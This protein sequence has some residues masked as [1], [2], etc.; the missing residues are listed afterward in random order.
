MLGANM[1]SS[2]ISPRRYAEG[3]D[4]DDLGSD[5]DSADFVPLSFSLLFGSPVQ[6]SPE[7]DNAPPFMSDT[8]G[9]TVTRCP[10]LCSILS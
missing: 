5:S 3:P 2:I 7:F 10:L 1:L 4:L 6:T 9:P 8:T